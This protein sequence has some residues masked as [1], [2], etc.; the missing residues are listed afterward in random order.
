MRNENRDQVFKANQSQ[1]FKVRMHKIFEENLSKCIEKYKSKTDNAYKLEQMNKM[2]KR[3]L[4]GISASG[5]GAIAMLAG[6]TAVASPALLTVGA[7][8]SLGGL[9]YAG[10]SKLVKEHFRPKAGM[11]QIEGD[12]V[13]AKFADQLD[14]PEHRLKEIVDARIREEKTAEFTNKSKNKNSL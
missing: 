4:G 11:N 12:S 1:L 2:D 7:V 14:I 6:A 13:I 8:A 3:M 5:V 10:I 9:A